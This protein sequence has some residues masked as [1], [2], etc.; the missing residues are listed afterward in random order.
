MAALASGPSGEKKKNRS[1]AHAVGGAFSEQ[2]F[3]VRIYSQ[4]SILGI[5]ADGGQPHTNTQ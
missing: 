4:P 2:I 5:P 1:E 3:W